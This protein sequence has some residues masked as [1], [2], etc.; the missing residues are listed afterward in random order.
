MCRDEFDDRQARRRRVQPARQAGERDH[1]PACG[2]RSRRV[3]RA[4]TLLQAYPSLPWLRR[5]A[6]VQAASSVATTR[7]RKSFRLLTSKF[8]ELLFLYLP[9]L[10]FTGS[11]NLRSHLFRQ[12]FWQCVLL[13]FGGL[14]FSTMLF[15]L[16]MSGMRDAEKQHLAE[17]VLISLLT[18]CPELMFVSDMNALSSARSHI[19]ETIIMGEPLIRSH[20]S[21]DGLP[22]QHACRR[23]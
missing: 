18:C 2:H 3:S 22:V 7:K 11:I 20:R 14:L 4:A 23:S 13:G 16:Y 5:W 12:C 15:M 1:P 17:M 9:V 8:R 19:L 6:S 10:T 21:L